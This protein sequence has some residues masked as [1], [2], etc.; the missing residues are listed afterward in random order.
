MAP[1]RVPPLRTLP[2]KGERSANSRR[3]ESYL[4]IMDQQPVTCVDRILARGC[5]YNSAFANLVL[6]L[7]SSLPSLAYISREPPKSV[8]AIAWPR[9]GLGRLNFVLSHRNCGQVCDITL[10]T[11]MVQVSGERRVRRQQTARAK[12]LALGVTSCE[13]SDERSQPRWRS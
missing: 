8:D 2:N 5:R 10:S 9:P 1:D 6:G 3:I 13:F 7:P 4:T 11:Q 12:Q